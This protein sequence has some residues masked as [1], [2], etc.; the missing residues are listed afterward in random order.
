METTATAW[1]RPSYDG[2]PD[3]RKGSEGSSGGVEQAPNGK[4]AKLR[5][6]PACGRSIRAPKAT[7]KQRQWRKA[8]LQTPQGQAY[9]ARDRERRR[10]AQAAL[11]FEQRVAVQQTQRAAVRNARAIVD[12][13]RMGGA[14]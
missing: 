5:H 2:R 14:A 4:G 7:A 6:C 1:Q 12:A 13:A 9:L 11:T 3:S 10:R 8:W